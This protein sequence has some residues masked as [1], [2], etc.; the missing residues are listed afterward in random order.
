MVVVVV[1]VAA[2]TL[3]NDVDPPL[4]GYDDTIMYST[5]VPE[6]EAAGTDADTPE[7]SGGTFFSLILR[8]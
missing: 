7:C 3:R 5:G 1:V 4:D 6:W 2:S 8:E